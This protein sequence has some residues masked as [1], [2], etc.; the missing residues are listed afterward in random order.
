EWSL[1]MHVSRRWR[2]LTGWVAGAAVSA[3]ACF[4][5]ADGLLESDANWDGPIQLTSLR[6][7]RPC[8][9]CPCPPGRP[10]TSTTEKG[11][12]EKSKEESA[13]SE[14]MPQNEEPF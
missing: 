4:T 10:E 8:T 3:S 2:Y 7:E 12:A 14:V 5:F 11:T 1:N 6:H 9:P 13:K